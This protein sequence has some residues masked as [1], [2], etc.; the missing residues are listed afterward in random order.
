VKFPAIEKSMLVTGVVGVLLLGGLGTLL[1]WERGAIADARAAG[2]ALRSEAD[3]AR[4]EIGKTAGLERDVIVQREL[5]E[6]MREILPNDQEI[7]EYVR[8]LQAFADNSGVSIS[9]LKPKNNARDD[10]QAKADFKKVGYEITFAGDAFQLLSFLSLVERHS[11]FMSVNTLK[12]SA[13]KRDDSKRGADKKPA[14]PRHEI[15]LE[16][17]SY[18][19]QPAEKGKPVQVDGYERKRDLLSTEISKQR[20]LLQ[21]QAYEYRGSRGRRD[22]WVDPRMPEAQEGEGRPIEEQI[23]IVEDAT[24]L[25][26]STHEL[27]MRMRTTS[28]PIE[29]MTLER[30]YLPALADLISRVDEQKRAGGFT[31]AP[32]KDA[33]QKNVL[34]VLSEM[35]GGQQPSADKGP[36]LAVLQEAHARM[37]SYRDAGEYKNVL[38]VF[39]SV[40]LMLDLAETY[41]DR[42]QLALELREFADEARTVL[43]FEKLS[44]SISGV[45]V[46]SGKPYAIINGQ[47]VEVGEVMEGGIVVHAIRQDEIEFEFRGLVLGRMIGQ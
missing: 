27:W 15:Q 16:V 24:R 14:T 11:R 28:S 37:N 39:A 19:Y 8:T 3:R 46:A 43:D 30:D 2:D 6:L 17:E 25:A 41:P 40:A 44:L 13:A 4:L 34:E 47:T 29:V 38:E 21:T 10:K 9:Q 20:A 32:A 12:L 36:S 23:A 5:D 1:W 35:Q 22:P 45:I 18:V 33:W 7:T 26:A 31:Y 42:A